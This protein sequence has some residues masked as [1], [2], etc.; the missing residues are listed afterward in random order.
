MRTLFRKLRSTS[1]FLTLVGACLVSSA[2]ASAEPARDYWAPLSQQQHESMGYI[3]SSLSRGNIPQLVMSK[4]R[5]R[6]A[7]AKLR[8]IHPFRYLCHIFGHQKYLQD[9]C[10][11]RMH[12]V[13]IWPGFLEG[14][15]QG[16]TDG[17]I[18]S[19][20]QEDRAGNLKDEYLRDLSTKCNLSFARMSVCI[21][22]KS[23]HEF[24]NYI[25]DE[26]TKRNTQELYD[27]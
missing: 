6:S 12:K 26:A 21:R 2:H 13:F 16:A 5:L 15:D 7:G 9:L 23:W 24:M 14:E 19:L 3:L 22:Q 4:S 17:I 25:L 11:I 10:E 1:L 18:G 27:I 8:D 20:K